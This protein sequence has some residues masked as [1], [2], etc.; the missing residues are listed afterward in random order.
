MNIYAIE[1]K[2]INLKKEIENYNS[3]IELYKKIMNNAKVNLETA[4]FDEP[5]TQAI[6]E[7]IPFSK[8]P[9]EF[10]IEFNFIIHNLMK[11]S[12]NERNICYKELDGLE[13]ILINISQPSNSLLN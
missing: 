2:I 4:V 12:I 7:K 6:I 8:L 9:E 10:I 1:E 11:L 5:G 3:T 13:N